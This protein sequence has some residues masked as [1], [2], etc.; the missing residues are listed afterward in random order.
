MPREG[1]KVRGDMGLSR[2]KREK[3]KKLW[4]EEEKKR[5]RGEFL[6]EKE[7]SSLKNQ[8]FG[9]KEGFLA[10][11][12]TNQLTIKPLRAN[13]FDQASFFSKNLY[14]SFKYQSFSII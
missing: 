8:I 1:E 6:R 10:C 14:S 2:R 4:K 3:E 5:K 13:H 12:Q 9:E 11:I 7:R